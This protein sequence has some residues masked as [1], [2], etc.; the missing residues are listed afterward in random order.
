VTRRR[1]LHVTQRDKERLPRLQ[2]LKAEHPCW[3]YRRVWAFWRFVEHLP[4]NRQRIWRLLREHHLLVP[5]HL[6]L[7]A[8]RTPSHSTPK[9]LKP[10]EWWGIDRTK[11]LV[12]GFGWVDIVVILDWYTKKVVG[13][14]AGI[15]CSAKHWLAALD[16]AV[17]RQFPAGAR[18]QG[19]SLMSDNG[20]QPTALA[21]MEACSTLNI[22]QAFTSENNPKGNADTE[23]VRRPLKEECLW[24]QEWTCPFELIQAF[25][26]W[27]ADYNEHDLHSTLG[28]KPPAQFERDYYRSHGPPFLAA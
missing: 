27:V 5:P 24:R 26:G 17:N 4:V 10:H 18:G 8:T 2:A 21:F 14:Y 16:M 15:Q 9:P 28:Y 12:P 22:H 25:E 11:V 13:Y 7:K 23:R 19:W 6:R 3:G 1:P 20:C